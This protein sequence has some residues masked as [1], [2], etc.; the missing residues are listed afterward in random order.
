MTR[1]DKEK[2]IDKVEA[3]L[4]KN[5]L[6]TARELAD[7]TWMWASTANRAKKEVAQNGTKDNRIISLT[8]NDFECIQLWVNEIKRRLQD[9]KE[10]EKM[11]TPE[12]SNVIKENTARYTLFRGDVTDSKWGMKST[13]S[14]M[15]TEELIKIVEWQ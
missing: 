4:A 5:P 15:S 13:A 9:E 7:N 1:T 14:E 8:D 2:N 12:I 10:L 11:R 6:Q 3:S